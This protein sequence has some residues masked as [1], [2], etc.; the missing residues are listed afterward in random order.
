[1]C[2]L[3]VWPVAMS[4]WWRVSAVMLNPREAES[5]SP[6]AVLGY[7]LRS[8]SILTLHHLGKYFWDSDKDDTT[9]S[10]PLISETLEKE[11]GCQE[12]P[13]WMSRESGKRFQSSGASSASAIERLRTQAWESDR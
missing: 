6:S 9:S 7:I 10:M 12:K 3:T 8:R 1:M 4:N 5:G 2:P 13:G 11:V